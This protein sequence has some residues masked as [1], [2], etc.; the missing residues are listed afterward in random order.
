MVG[1]GYVA[2]FHNTVKT[3]QSIIQNKFQWN[4][5]AHVQK[6]TSGIITILKAKLVAVLSLKETTKRFVRRLCGSE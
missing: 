6:F 1:I 2:D 3:P 4:F 5:V